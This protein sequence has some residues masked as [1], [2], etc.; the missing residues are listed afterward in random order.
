[1]K[2]DK[3]YKHPPLRE[4][5]R[6]LEMDERG[7]FWKINMGD[8]IYLLLDE[9]DFPHLEGRRYSVFEN[10]N[11]RYAWASHIYLH[12]DMMGLERG[13]SLTVDH[14]DGNGLNCRRYNMRVC[15]QYENNSSR[16]TYPRG[17]SGWRGVYEED[18]GW[19]AVIWHRGK[20]I[21]VG[22]F[23]DP[24]TAARAYDVRAIALRGEFTCLNFPRENYA[25]EPT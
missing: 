16:P 20:Q 2:V 8:G 14:R 19:K 17:K 12:R 3:R 7:S 24:V 11:C 4:R 6:V 10:D 18:G 21:Y 25:I 13:D 9:S 1:M 23:R 5:Q 22:G 15:T